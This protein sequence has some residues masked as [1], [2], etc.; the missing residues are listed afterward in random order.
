MSRVSVLPSLV[1]VGLAAAATATPAAAETIRGVLRFTDADGS[2]KPI[3]NAKVEV[4]RLRPGAV[5]W[6]NDLTT[7]T[8]GTGALDAPIG[9]V[10]AGTRT[11]LRVFATNDAAQVMTQDLLVPFYRQPGLPGPEIQR[12]T[13]T[14]GDFLDFTFTFPDAWAN[15][16]FNIAD[17][18]KWGRDYAMG[19]R[20]PRESDPINRVDVHFNSLTTYYDPVLHA[21]RL[22]PTFAMDDFTVVHEYTH[23]LEE[24]IGSFYGI[25]SIHDGC[26]ATNIDPALPGAIDLRGPGL[27]WMEGFASYLPQAVLRATG[28]LVGGPLTGSIPAGLLESPACPPTNLPPKA[29]ERPVAGT[30]FDLLDD[31]SGAEP[32]DQLARRDVEIFQIFDRELDLGWT[33]PTLDQF[34]AAWLARG[35]D[36][37]QFLMA[38][39]ANGIVLATPSPTE[40]VAYD[41]LVAANLAVYRPSDAR[42]YVNGGELPPQAWGGIAGDI[43]VPADYDGDGL[44]DLAIRRVADGTWWVRNSQ[45]GT[46]RTFAQGVP[47]DRPLVADYDGDGEDDFA[48]IRANGQLLVFGDTA[49]EQRTF[50]SFAIAGG[51]A[52][53]GDF[54]GDSKPDLAIYEPSTGVFWIT[55]LFGTGGWAF[56]TVGR[57]FAD[58]VP[59]PGDYIF[60]GKQELAVYEPST[61]DFRVLSAIG[62]TVVA[63]PWGFPGELPVPAD[64]D[65][66]GDTDRATWNPVNGWWFISN[67]AGDTVMRQWGTA[68]DIA[69]PAP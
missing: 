66:D 47:S 2:A 12:V 56:P 29:L 25:A 45:G 32:L 38:L 30:L 17:A 53:V 36:A 57:G 49:A 27:A 52:V 58:D 8:D 61:G 34:G 44:T 15:N 43:P 6:T 22:S 46:I 42:W 39:G 68:G 5:L 26:R 14:A 63:S 20:D 21:V 31:A 11:A 64:Y 18:I 59:V 69:V 62:G 54:V 55:S 50:Y 67:N 19:R 24:Q 23:Y 7:A 13:S 10:G 51:K 40:S 33:N 9:F 28:A 41:H 48:L 60:G 4:W 1:A 16:H 3:R 37:P 65:G 35:L